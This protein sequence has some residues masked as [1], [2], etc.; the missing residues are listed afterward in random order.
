MLPLDKV[1]I[2]YQEYFFF[3]EAQKYA[4]AKTV[5][6]HTIQIKKLNYNH[7]NEYKKRRF[8]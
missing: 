8:Y 2:L 1:P 5:R 4:V 7:V 3:T 6:G